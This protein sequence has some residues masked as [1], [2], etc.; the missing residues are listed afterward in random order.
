MLVTDITHTQARPWTAVAVAALLLVGST[1]GAEPVGFVALAEGD[2]QIRASAGTSFAA[3]VPDA[4]VSIGDT[5]RT[6]R[7]GFAKIVL[8]DDTILTLDEE[9]ELAIDEFVVG[10][11]ATSEPSKLSLVT[12][13]VRTKVGEAFG[14]TTRLEM[15]TPTAVIGVKGT[16]WLTWVS[17]QATWVCVI[18]GLV[19]LESQDAA[20]T[21]GYEAP[22]GQCAKIL[23]HLRPEPGEMPTYLNAIQ[24]IQSLAPPPA[25]TPSVAAGGSSERNLRQAAREGDLSDPVIENQADVLGARGTFGAF[26][27]TP[28]ET[29]RPTPQS[30]ST[31]PSLPSFGGGGSGNAGGFSGG[32]SGNPGGG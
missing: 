10:P 4:D 11:A 27:P 1:A 6:G 32:G 22:A 13:H 20:V 28:E 12:G 18:S 26:D 3:A 17:E 9:T 8:V 5:I 24:A 30:T 16:E 7:D 29:G 21:G 14:G 23:P 19:L 31:P 15:H 2:V 25:V